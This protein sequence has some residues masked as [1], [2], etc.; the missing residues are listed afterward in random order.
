MQQIVHLLTSNSSMILV[1][2][3]K[4]YQIIS[5]YSKSSNKCKISLWFI[6]N[7]IPEKL[8]LKTFNLE[9]FIYVYVYVYILYVYITH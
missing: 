1:K 9:D 7:L 3:H 8:V 4:K 2:A 6:R 5:N